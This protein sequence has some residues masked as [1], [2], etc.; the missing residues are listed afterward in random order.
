MAQGFNVKSN[1]QRY[2]IEEECTTGWEVYQ[3]NLTREECQN[4]YDFMINEG[5]SPSRIKIT[6]IQ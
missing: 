1:H 2:K 6:R 4:V 5:I 3:T